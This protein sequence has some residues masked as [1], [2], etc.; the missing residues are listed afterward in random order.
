M[1]MGY[2]TKQNSILSDIGA[3]YSEEIG[4]TCKSKNNLLYL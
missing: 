3:K 4:N 1:E 2:I